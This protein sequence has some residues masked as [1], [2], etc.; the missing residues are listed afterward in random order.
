MYVCKY[1]LIKSLYSIMSITAKWKQSISQDNNGKVHNNKNKKEWNGYFLK[2]G[3][4][5][6]KDEKL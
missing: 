5:E 1:I 4:N 3:L 2:S 6:W